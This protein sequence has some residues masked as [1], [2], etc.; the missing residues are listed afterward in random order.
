MLEVMVES[1]GGMDQM[2][3]WGM[4]FVILFPHK[5]TQALMDQLLV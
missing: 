3:I 4:L 2:K 1:A 5:I